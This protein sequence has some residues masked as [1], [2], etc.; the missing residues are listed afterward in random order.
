MQKMPLTHCPVAL[1]LNVVGDRW[2]LLILR[3]LLVEKVCR[4]QE[5]QNSLT[6][7]ATNTLSARLQSLEKHGI[8]ERHFY[9]DHPPRAEYVLSAKGKKLG[10]VVQALYKFGAEFGVPTTNEKT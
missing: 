8:V 10:P 4:F 1:A 2:T 7:I 5:L 9:S 3:D 6:G